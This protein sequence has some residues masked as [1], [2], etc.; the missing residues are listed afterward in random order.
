MRGVE[1][2]GGGK[3]EREDDVVQAQ[4]SVCGGPRDGKEQT[5]RLLAP[6]GPG[7][8]QSPARNAGSPRVPVPLHRGTS[9][10]NQDPQ[11]CWHLSALLKCLCRLCCLGLAE[12]CSIHEQLGFMRSEGSS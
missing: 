11:A 1:R 12:P 2:E 8:P 5:G 4:G 3:E 7:L 6:P 9:D 10:S